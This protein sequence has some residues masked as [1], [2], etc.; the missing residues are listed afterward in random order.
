VNQQPQPPVEWASRRVL[1]TGADGFVGFWLANALAAHGAQTC[2]LI[3][4]NSPGNEKFR[5]RRTGIKVV[6]GDIT[7]LDFISRLVAD[8]TI[9]IVYHLAAINT[10][11]GSDLSPYEIFETNIRG[12]YTV[13]E[14]CRTAP[15]PARAVVASSKEVENCFLPGTNRTHHPYMTSK[16]AAELVTRAYS[17][18]F[19]LSVALVRSDNIYGGGDFNWSRLVP[20]TIRSILHGETP[21]IRGNGLL[22]RDYVYIED[23]VAAYIAIGEHLDDAAAKGKLFHVATGLETNVLDMVKQITR[24]AGRPDLK[25]QVLN[26]KSEERI[27]IFYVP[28][29]EQTVFGWKSRYS[30]EEGLSRTCEWYRNCFKEDPS[31]IGAQ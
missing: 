5:P 1:V 22:Q 20:G 23:A 26:E 21:V 7:N 3:G 28:E 2:A 24:A 12:V 19:G 31:L 15:K 9:E 11:T 18:T 29:F 4:P 10:N 16:A 8:S 6:R 13:L 30:L 17:D 14:A 25:P 27:D